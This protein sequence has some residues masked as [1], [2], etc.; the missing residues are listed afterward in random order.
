MI[1]FPC[2]SDKKHKQQTMVRQ[3]VTDLNTGV[4]DGVHASQ[5]VGKKILLI[6]V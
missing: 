4:V 3:R 6:N 5:G 1:T 2:Q